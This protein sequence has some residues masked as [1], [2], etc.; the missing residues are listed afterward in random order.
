MFGAFTPDGSDAK[1]EWPVISYTKEKSATKHAKQA[2]MWARAKGKELEAKL[3][4]TKMIVGAPT[5]WDPRLVMWYPQPVEYFVRVI[6][7]L[8]SEE[9]FVGFQETRV[10]PCGN[11]S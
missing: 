11:G 7:L 8:D 2:T 3:G 9:E 4:S 10:S 1:Y 5:P 6:D